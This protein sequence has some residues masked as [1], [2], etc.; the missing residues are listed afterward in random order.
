MNCSIAICAVASCMATRSASDRRYMRAMLSAATAVQVPYLRRLEFLEL[1][2]C[3][4]R[5]TWAQLQVTD[6][7][8]D[9]PDPQGHPNAHTRPAWAVLSATLCIC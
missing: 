7:A 1:L 3:C 8:L 9:V 4:K 2:L 6:T 5:H